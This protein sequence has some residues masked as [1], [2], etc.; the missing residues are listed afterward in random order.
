MVKDQRKPGDIWISGRNSPDLVA[1]I[2]EGMQPK[3]I[4][5]ILMVGADLCNQMALKRLRKPNDRFRYACM[6]DIIPSNDGRDRLH[7][8]KGCN[9]LKIVL[10]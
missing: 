10:V 4:K 1:E 7:F 5:K 8:F 2:V 6:R 9:Y 3:D